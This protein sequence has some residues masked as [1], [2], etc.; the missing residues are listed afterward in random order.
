MI[1]IDITLNIGG[2]D[3]KIDYEEGKTLFKELF[4]LYGSIPR[5]PVS[6][7]GEAFTETD[8]SRADCGSSSCD[9]SMDEF[10]ND[11]KAS[12][13]NCSSGI[14]VPSASSGYIKTTDHLDK[15]I[16]SDSPEDLEQMQIDIDERIAAMKKA[17]DNEN[18]K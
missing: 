4:S 12:S 5:E 3:I 14:S 8:D 11:G 15:K 10:K 1:K 16:Q 7:Y 6:I 9:M 17:V 13:T 18:N 2:K